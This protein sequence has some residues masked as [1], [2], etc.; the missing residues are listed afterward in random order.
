MYRGDFD[1][2][3]LMHSRPYEGEGTPKN[4]TVWVDRFVALQLAQSTIWATMKAWDLREMSLNERE[5]IAEIMADLDICPSFREGQYELDIG[6]GH[7]NE[8]ETWQYPLPTGA[9]YKV[10]KHVEEYWAMRAAEE[11][12][13]EIRERAA[14]E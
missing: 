11:L 7:F 2:G 9:T 6:Y 1:E 8:G 12:G 14:F 13:E 4:M 3:I 10:N 5:T